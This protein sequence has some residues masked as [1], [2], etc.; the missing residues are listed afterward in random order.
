[1]FDAIVK[2]EKTAG[3]PAKKVGTTSPHFPQG[4]AN[5]L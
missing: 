2:L 5:V 3:Q 1:M 4:D